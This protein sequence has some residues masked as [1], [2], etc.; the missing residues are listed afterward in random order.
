MAPKKKGNKKGGDDWEA[1]LG[2]TIAPVDVSAEPKAEEAGAEDEAPVNDLMAAIQRRKKKKNKG[3]DQDFVQGEDPTADAPVD[4]ESK[5]PEEGNFDEDDVFAGNFNKKK[6]KAAA[7]AEKKD[8]E[9]KVD[10]VDD[11]APKVKTKAE[12]EK[13]KKEKEKQ[14]KKELVC[15]LYVIRTGT[16]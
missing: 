8:E 11:G 9:A 14:R 5:A 15:P 16:R 3:G 7:P 2:E 6:G 10:M 13:E 4:L 12:K 1:E